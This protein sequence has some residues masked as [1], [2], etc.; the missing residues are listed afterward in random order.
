[1][2]YYDL[3]NL[4]NVP[5]EDLPKVLHYF[6]EPHPF[7]PRPGEP[8]LRCEVAP[9]K[10]SLGFTFRFQAGYEMRVPL[11]QYTGEGHRWTVA[12]RV[13]PE[14]GLPVYFVQRFRLPK[15]PEPNCSRRSEAVTWWAKGATAS[16]GSCWTTPG[17]FTARTGAW[18]ARLGLGERNVKVAIPPGT[19]SQFSLVGVRPSSAATDAA[20]LR[21]TILLHAASLSPGRTRLRAADLFLLITTL[22]SLLEQLPSRSIKLVVFNLDQ[23]KE[24]FRQDGFTPAELD[25]VWQSM[26][27]LELGVVDYRTLGNRRGAIDLLESLVDEEYRAQ[28][29]SD[30]VVFLGPPVRSL[31]PAPHDVAKI[32]Q[33]PAPRFYY[34][35]YSP[36][37]FG[38]S[39]T[40]SGQVQMMQVTGDT[41]SRMVSRLQGR[42]L[43]IRTPGDLA[44][45]IEQV[46][47]R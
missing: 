1:M 36:F 13:T 38:W 3:P 22:S 27:G 41:I 2:G 37:L 18:Q 47:R 31:G 10:P 17:G 40:V 19:V 9:V 35:Q 32:P 39:R 15:I 29:P 23:Q 16:R 33:A 6:K 12:V 43:S 26:S 42:I 20:P 46:E 45:A 30:A 4:L 21:L 11:S 34:F 8:R 7:D 24:I 25:Q 5:G 44:K 14:G 28:T